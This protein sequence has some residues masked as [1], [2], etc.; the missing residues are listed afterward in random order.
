MA[1]TLVTHA[2]SSEELFGEDDALVKDHAATSGQDK[3]D[4]A[5]PSS[6]KETTA[7]ESTSASSSSTEAEDEACKE[8]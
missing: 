2:G 3:G 5:G 4:S 6:V 8:V 1:G 7:S